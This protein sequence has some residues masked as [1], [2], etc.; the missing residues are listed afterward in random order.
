MRLSLLDSALLLGYFALVS[1]IA[2]R[3]SREARTARSFLIGEREI[4]WWAAMLSIIGTEMS[5]LTFV[6]VPAFA[7]A[8]TGNYTYLVGAVGMVLAR[9]IVS[10]WFVPAY[11]RYNVVSIYELLERRFGP[12]TRAGAVLIFLFTRV[13]MSGVRLYAGSIVVQVAL[14]I[15][16]QAAIVA[17]AALGLVYTVLGGIRSVIWTE[18]LQ[19]GVMFGGA[20]AAA[21][22]LFLSLPE[23]W[24]SVAQAT[25]GLDKFRLLD[26][27]LDLYDPQQEFT[28]WGGPAGT[29]RVQPVGVRHRLRHGAAHAYHAR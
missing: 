19:V 4:P 16:W 10:R 24:T 2:W 25:E 17:T 15:P 13:A 14:G 9:I 20:L 23:G 11:Y 6:G 7:Y 22:I 8:T 5:A 28:V 26:F 1:W 3:S 29:H 18:V 21:A 12:W 27:R